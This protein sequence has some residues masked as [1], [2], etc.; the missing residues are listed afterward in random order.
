M[1]NTYQFTHRLAYHAPLLEASAWGTRTPMVA[2]TYH[3]GN[4]TTRLMPT[5]QSTHTADREPP[6]PTNTAPLHRMLK[7]W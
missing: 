4:S 7:V 3:S 6:L 2:S 5:A 1:N